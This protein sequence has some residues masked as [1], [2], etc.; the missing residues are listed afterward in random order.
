MLMKNGYWLNSLEFYL[1]R[2]V[3]PA[4]ILIN[5]AEALEKVTPADVA[6]MARRVLRNDQYVRVTLYPDSSGS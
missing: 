1:T 2:D 3:D 5:P 6:D 4:R